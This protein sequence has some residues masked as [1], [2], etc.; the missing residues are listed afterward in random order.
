[1]RLK[2]G[3]DPRIPGYVTRTKFFSSNWE[4]CRA[5]CGNFR[6]DPWAKYAK[7]ALVEDAEIPPR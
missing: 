4:D 7:D 2:T 5:N 6:M 3:K 1:M